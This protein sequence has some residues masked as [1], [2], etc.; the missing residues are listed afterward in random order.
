MTMYDDDRV[1]ALL[2]D[3]DVPTAPPDRLGQ[4]SRR[5]RAH[6][7][8]RSSLVA[9]SMALVLV[10]GIIG[11]VSLHGRS[12]EQVLT[13][14]D[15]ARATQNAG[16][17]RL[18]LRISVTRSTNP[19]LPV[20]DLMR[21]SG[22]VD[23]R[24]LRYQLTGTF[25]KS[26]IEVRGIDRDEWTKA[27]LSGSFLAIAG[28][29]GASQKPW[30]HSIRKTTGSVLETVDPTELLDALT[31]K[32]TTLRRTTDGDRT[33]TVLQIS[34]DVL[35]A[36]AAGAGKD[37]ELTVESDADGR[38]RLLSYDTDTSGLGTTRATIAYDDFGIDVQVS[39][40]PAD[41]VQEGS[42]VTGSDAQTKTFS[43][44]VGSSPA[45]RQRACDMLTTFE[46]NAP[47]ATTAEQKAG[48]EQFLSIARKACSRK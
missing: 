36:G 8:R 17:A 13:V 2:R 27:D 1:V 9:G 39:P 32:G 14:A 22:P 38:I 48:Y 26:A 30:T 11:A 25:Q 20:G 37:V 31:T 21:L 19:L 29:A 35:G 47:K 15:A 24:H 23:F 12:N 40:P 33:K 46:R 34:E 6:E 41:Q 16:S 7:T 5:A 10:G 4:V 28:A 3:I 44:T 18:T 45:D 42:A 43:G